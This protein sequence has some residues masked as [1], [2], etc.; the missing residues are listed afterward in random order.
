MQDQCLILI[1]LSALK[2]MN[3]PT[4][5]DYQKTKKKTTNF[6]YSSYSLLDRLIDVGMILCNR[7]SKET[8]TAKSPNLR[9]LQRKERR[10][11][12]SAY[13]MR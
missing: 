12:G 5:T 4:P 3:N 7:S 10:K 8:T 2:G 11:L 6:S 9:V 13:H 1:I